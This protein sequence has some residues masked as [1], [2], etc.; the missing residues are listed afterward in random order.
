MHG[1]HRVPLAPVASFLLSQV[2]PIHDDGE[3][4]AEHR[5][6][7][8]VPALD[9]AVQLQIEELEPQQEHHAEQYVLQYLVHPYFLSV[10]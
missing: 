3:Q 8:H 6:G 9:H 1:R 2:E 5:V 10:K 7:Q 4:E